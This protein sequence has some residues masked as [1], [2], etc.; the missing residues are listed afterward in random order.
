MLIHAEVLD[1]WCP[2]C[3]VDD[4]QCDARCTSMSECGTTNG[5]EVDWQHTAPGSNAVP[6]NARTNVT[7]ILSNKLSSPC[8]DFMPR[9][10]PEQ[11]EM[12]RSGKKFSSADGTMCAC[13]RAV[14]LATERSDC[15]D[16]CRA[17]Q[18]E[19]RSGRTHAREA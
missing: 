2:R 9:S 5:P 1:H 8:R 15:R 10:W 12:L 13:T 17:V 18:F 11:F 19:S 14:P 3:S 6:N 16:T 4:Q 7:P